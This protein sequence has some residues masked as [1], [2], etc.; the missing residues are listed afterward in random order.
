MRNLVYCR[1][2]NENPAEEPTGL[3][4]SQA[5]MRQSRGDRRPIPTNRS[6]SYGV[7]TKD[8]RLAT[9]QGVIGGCDLN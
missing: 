4:F 1:F 9:K 7:G 8:C 3:W 2:V 6:T 5:I